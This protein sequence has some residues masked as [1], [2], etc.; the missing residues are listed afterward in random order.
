[1]RND[2][3]RGELET[4]LSEVLAKLRQDGDR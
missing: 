2:G 3:T 4:K 1:V